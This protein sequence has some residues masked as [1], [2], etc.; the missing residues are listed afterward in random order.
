MF[1]LRKEQK[2]MSKRKTIVKITSILLVVITCFSI[3]CISASAATWRTGKVPNSGN[4][5]YTTVWLSNTSKN[6][7]IKIH[8]Y[9]YLINPNNASEKS[10]SFHVTMR[11]TADVGCGKVTLPLDL[12]ARHLIWD[13][14]ILYTRF[15]SVKTAFLSDRGLLTIPTTGASSA[16][17]IATSNRLV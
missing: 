12:T 8:S 9:T 1:N 13:A 15:V 3:M 17:R 5:G 2:F 6:A 11:N 4:S 10:T 7:N 16:Y 14:T